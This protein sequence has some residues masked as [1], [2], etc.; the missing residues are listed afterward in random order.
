[1][2]PMTPSTNT[3]NPDR[4]ANGWTGNQRG[5]ALILAIIMLVVLSLLGSVALISSDTEMK[6]TG[7]YQVAKQTFWVADRAVEYATSRDMLMTMGTSVNLVTADGGVHKTRIEAAGG[8]FL[9]EGSIQ[10]LGAG[11]L[12]T[13]LAGSYGSDFGANYYQVSVTARQRPDV[14][15]PPTNTSAAVRID[16]TILRIFKNEDE[17][18]FVTT[19]GG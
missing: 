10:D 4:S 12:P 8:G 13:S 17:N 5:A 9:T 16:S 3:N 2:L 7:N 1:M 15:S 11:A 18:I 6:V 19:G 14:G